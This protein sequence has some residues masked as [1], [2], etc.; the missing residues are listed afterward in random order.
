MMLPLSEKLAH[1]LMEAAD[2]TV[3]I[4][5]EDNTKAHGCLD[6]EETWSRGLFRRIHEEWEQKSIISVKGA[7]TVQDRQLERSRRFFPMRA[8][9][10]SIY[11]VKG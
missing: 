1:R 3:Y 7:G 5:Y 8:A 9:A 4:I 11:Q 10:L 2:L 6:T